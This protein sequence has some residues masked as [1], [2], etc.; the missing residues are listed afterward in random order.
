MAEEQGRRRE[1]VG[2][3]KDFPKSRD[4]VEEEVLKRGVLREEA[5][6]QGSRQIVLEEV[7]KEGWVAVLKW[8]KGLVVEKLVRVM[9][10][11]C[12]RKLVEAGEGG[13]GE[14]DRQEEE[15]AGGSGPGT[16]RSP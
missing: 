13:A 7:L 16:G 5:G 1:G 6:E 4:P 14:M 8:E 2:C 12:I 3:N 10:E 9:A 15:G 11:V